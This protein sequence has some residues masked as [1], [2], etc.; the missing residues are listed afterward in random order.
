MTIEEAIEIINNYKID[1]TQPGALRFVGALS[2]AVKVMQEKKK[3]EQATE[4][5]QSK[6]KL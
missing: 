5:V 6:E 4:N 1:T 2:V 3:N